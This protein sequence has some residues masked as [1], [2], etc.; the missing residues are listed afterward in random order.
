[1]KLGK[2]G[3]GQNKIYFFF[4]EY[5]NEA[6]RAMMTRLDDCYNDCCR[7]VLGSKYLFKEN[8]KAM[9][10]KYKDPL[11]Q[12][13]GPHWDNANGEQGRHSKCNT[14]RLGEKELVAPS[15]VTIRPK[16]SANA[17]K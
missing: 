5:L 14:K 4:G 10:T 15:D 12:E 8:P 11:L 3:Q 13:P 17:P 6:V 1:M 9:G 7:N 16:T 2:I